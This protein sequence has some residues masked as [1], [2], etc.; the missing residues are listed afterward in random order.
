MQWQVRSNAVPMR[1]AAVPMRTAAV[2]MRTAAVPMRTAAVPMRT[3]NLAS[4]RLHCMLLL[5]VDLSFHPRVPE[6]LD[7]VV[8]SAR[9]ELGNHAPLT[10]VPSVAHSKDF[11][12]FFTPRVCLDVW[13]Q[14]IVPS[15]TTLLASARHQHRPCEPAPLL[16]SMLLHPFHHHI[17]LPAR[18]FGAI[19]SFCHSLRL[20]AGVECA[21]FIHVVCWSLHVQSSSGSLL[22]LICA[23]SK[24]LLL[25]V[26]LLQPRVGLVQRECRRS[27]LTTECCCSRRHRQLLEARRRHLL[28]YL[29]CRLAPFRV[30]ILL[31]LVLPAVSAH[32]SSM[33]VHN[34]SVAVGTQQ[35][36]VSI[37]VVRQ[38]NS[39]MAVRALIV[40]TTLWQWAH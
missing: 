12:F 37:T 31:V 32:N 18:P 15:L 26:Q 8:C 7:C 10:P 6:V 4:Y 11:H 2:A 30:L 14:M 39:S 24:A 33:S 21:I 25:L 9:Q 38:H 3:A 22:Q 1:T 28:Q 23:G 40:S 16:R 35:I 19:S 36:F 13:M 29:L 5:N 34:S 20:S 17:V 27:Q